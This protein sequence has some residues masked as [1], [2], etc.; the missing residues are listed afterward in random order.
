VRALFAR[1]W[2]RRLVLGGVVLVIVVV[3]G[4]FVYI[5]FIEGTAPPRL[6][7]PTTTSTGASG[8]APTADQSADGTWRISSGS[9]AGYRVQEVL[10]GQDNTAVGRT[11][12]ITGTVSIA[13]SAVTAGS[14]TVNLSTVTSDRSQRDGQF[15]G[16]IMNVARYP[17]ATF[18]LSQPITLPAG[19]ESGKTVSVQATGQLTLH[20]TTRQ[21]AV[22]MQ[23]RLS[24]GAMQV[25]G[26]IPITFADWNITNPSL[27]PV[28]TQDHG[29]MEFLLNLSRS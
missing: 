26:S 20:G 13:H 12:D 3:G 22:S 21:V 5:H 16:R 17:N 1:R 9:Q 14:F 23:A 7:I 28:T 8:S 6:A 15:R 19:A 29:T 11:G 25:S 18:V 27:G 10:F 2:V 4:P 24:G